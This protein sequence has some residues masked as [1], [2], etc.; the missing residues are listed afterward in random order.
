[1][2]ETRRKRG[3]SRSTCP[4]PNGPL[5][6]PPRRN[7]TAP[8]R[9]PPPAAT[10]FTPPAFVQPPHAKHPGVSRRNP[11]S[12]PPHPPNRRLPAPPHVAARRLRSRGTRRAPRTTPHDPA[13]QR[14]ASSIAR[15]HRPSRPAPRRAVPACAPS[16]SPRPTRRRARPRPTTSAATAG[17]VTE[18]HRPHRFRRRLAPAA[19]ARAAHRPTSATP[20]PAPGAA[21]QRP[22]PPPARRRSPGAWA[23][24]SRWPSSR[25]PTRRNRQGTAS[26]R[27][28]AA[29]HPLIGHLPRPFGRWRPPTEPGRP[30]VPVTPSA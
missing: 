14:P 29:K 18:S 19:S 8:R 5:P 28:R 20:P 23:G 17:V 6:G 9:S 13:S 10:R 27:R 7:P 25:S 11:P 4:C 3:G 2:T 1:M 26:R 15:P 12:I 16:P 21:P 24:G 30:A 22:F